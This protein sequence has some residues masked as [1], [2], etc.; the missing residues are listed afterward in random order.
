MKRIAFILT[1][2]LWLCGGSSL[3]AWTLFD[4]AA[5]EEL[6]EEHNFNPDKDIAF[7]PEAK[8]KDMF[9][10]VED[11]SIA[12]KTQVRK[13]IDVYLNSG[14][15]FTINGIERSGL[16]QDIINEVFAKHPDMPA[17]L[18][19]LPMLESG[20]NPKAVSRSNAVGL[21]QFMRN[22]SEPLGLKKNKWVDDRRSIEKSTDAALR[23]LRGLYKAFGS[24]EL[25]LAAYNGG[26]GHVRRSMNKSGANDFWELLDAKVLHKE[27]SEYVPRFIALL[28]IYRNQEMFGISSDITVKQPAETDTIKLKY[29]VPLNA[30]SKFSGTPIDS[31][32]KFNPELAMNVTPPS[33]GFEL[34]LPV[35]NAKRLETK[36]DSLYKYRV[37]ETKTQTYTVKKGDTLSAIAKKNGTNAA[38]LMK[39]NN[40]KNAN[41]II[42]GKVL[43]I[44][45]K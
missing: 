28:L 8:H 4:I 16:Y 31:I 22:T 40:I 6:S 44:P 1:L 39:A 32:R 2:C 14:R 21:W 34:R 36:M 24:W 9:A 11:M 5:G 42:P 35:E 29:S 43:R 17:D 10:A 19:L 20:F 15:N 41:K 7:L 3:F 33:A 12:R 30:V 27:T 37:K 25:A 13:F 18:S 45:T 26:G 38:A 23:H